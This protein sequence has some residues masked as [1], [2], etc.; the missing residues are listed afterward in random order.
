MCC[1]FRY[2]FVTLRCK[3]QNTMA[4]VTIREK[5]CKDGRISLYLDIYSKGM[6]RYEF[7]DLHIVPEHN[8]ADRAENRRNRQLADVIRAKRL[9]EVQ[10]NTYGFATSYDRALLLPTFAKFM[11][12]RNTSVYRAVLHHL[13]D[14]CAKAMQVSQITE[15]WVR[16]F[17]D[18]L[19]VR[20]SQSTISQY[21]TALKVFWAW[22]QKRNI[23]Q[24]N[25]FDDIEVK[26][27]DKEREYLTLDELRRLIDTP[28]A[29]PV[30]DAFLFSCLTG[31]RISDIE[32]L[33]WGD[34]EE[35]GERRRIRFVQKK[36]KRHTYV[37]LNAQTSELMGSRRKPNDVVFFVGGKVPNITLNRNIGKWCAEAG[38]AKHI[39]FHC[40]RHTFATM[41]LTL[42][43]SIY[44]VSKLLGHSSVA[45]TQI[46]AKIVDKKRQEAV[47]SI[48]QLLSNAQ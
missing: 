33:R 3:T 18:D 37:E 30:R 24:G 6:R 34:V 32:R 38:I 20:C 19:S 12:G 17:I 21:I 5:E 31:L 14:R 28:C 47:D 35:D 36:T 39:T 48:P 2:Y 13:E 23:V 44:V 45:T 29:H 40:A 43:N 27:D 41:L 9:L 42:D 46:Y 8:D 15:R 4:S 26:R 10:N 7:L 16:E 11:E 25:P 1:F 22:A